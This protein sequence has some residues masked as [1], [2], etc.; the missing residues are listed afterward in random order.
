MRRGEARRVKVRLAE[1][2]RGE[3]RSCSLGDS[4]DGYQYIKLDRKQQTSI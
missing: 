2:R 4:R 3:V 1:V